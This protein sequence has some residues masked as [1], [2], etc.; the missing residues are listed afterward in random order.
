MWKKIIQDD[1]VNFEKL[2]ATP[3]NSNIEFEDD[4]RDF[5]GGYV[6]VRKDYIVSKKRIS[7]ESEWCRVFD[8]WREGVT[9]ASTVAS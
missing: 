7:T 4:G 3:G 1:Y 9:P 5:G 2:Y 6:F 8:A